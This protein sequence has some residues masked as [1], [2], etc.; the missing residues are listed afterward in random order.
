MRSVVVVV[1]WAAG[2]VTVDV[3]AG[4]THFYEP[5][6]SGLGSRPFPVLA[7]WTVTRIPD[8]FPVEA[9]SA[10]QWFV[11]VTDDWGLAHG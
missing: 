9:V 11:R 6:P 8:L 3:H 10:W 4:P 2:V 1:V 7:C 5:D